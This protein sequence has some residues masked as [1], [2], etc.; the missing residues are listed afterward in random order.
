MQD[1]NIYIYTDY[2]GSFAK[3]HGKWHV[4]L[5]CEVMTKSGKT[6][7]A[8]M[9]E[10]GAEESITKNRLELLALVKAMEHLV[11]PCN[12]T[13]YTMS[14]YIYNAYSQGWLKGWIE[15]GFKKNGKKVKHADLWKRVEELSPNHEIQVELV[16]KTSYT[17][18]Q[19][20]EMEHWK[21]T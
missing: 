7:T 9:K 18:V 6:E 5:E 11:K 4:L 21:E 16:E 13:I 3:G 12:V 10:L 15:S 2:K 17:A 8:T 1:V 19:R 14:Q 20:V